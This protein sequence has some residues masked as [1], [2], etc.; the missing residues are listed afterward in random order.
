[1]TKEKT[2]MRKL[3]LQVQ[4]TV[5]GYIARPNGEMDF[6]VWNWDDELK[7]Y[8]AKILNLLT[9][10]FLD[11]NLPKGSFLTGLPWL[12]IRMTRSLQPVRNL[13]THTKLFLPKRLTCQN[14]TIPF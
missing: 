11:E 2:T 4:M 8:V 13:R 9:A 7:Q 6:M 3:K 10:L 14:G 12:Q 5:D 1:M